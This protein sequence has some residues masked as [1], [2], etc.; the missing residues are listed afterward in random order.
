MFERLALASFAWFAIH[1][2]VAGSELRWWLVRRLGQRGFSAFF[3]LLSLASLLFLIDA[4]RKATFYPLWFSPQI[5]HWLPLVVM[6]FALVLLVGAFSVPNPT[7]VGAE[8]VLERTDAARGVLRIT[9]H[10]FLWATAL[11]SGAHLLVTGHIAAILFFGT[12]LATALRGTASIDEKRRRTN[13]VEFTR[14]LEIT[15]NVPFAAIIL[16]KNRLAW[17][18]LWV[19][20]VIAA[21]LTAVLLHMHLRLFGSSPFG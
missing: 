5:I 14:Y 17:S 7:A 16:G 13:K 21:L 15:S 3:S 20:M 11:W 12:M 10:P 8:K 1:A 19:P 18:E 2:F 4:Y 6:P 9:R